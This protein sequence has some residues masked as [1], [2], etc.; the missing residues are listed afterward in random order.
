MTTRAPQWLTTRPIAHRGLHERARGII[1]NTPSAIG[2]AIDNHFAFEVDLQATLDGEAMVYHDDELGRLTDGHGA[3]REINSKDLRH[4][5]FRETTDRMIS[6]GE[7]CEIVSGRVTMVLELK[8]QFDDNDMLVRRVAS[9]LARYQGPVAAMSFDPFQ[10]H[11]LRR[12]APNV[13]RGLV[14]ENNYEQGEWLTLPP[15]KRN[16]MKHMRQ[17][18]HAQPQFIAYNINDLPSPAPWIARTL[19]GLP[20]LTWTVR[21]P[22]QRAHAARWTDQMIFETFIPSNE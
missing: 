1:E 12:L 3:L 22:D 5:P 6:L 16:M 11:A 2:A 7:L 14:A 8:S 20:L 10:V 4:V 19:F 13:V 15:A 17:A 9:V 18:F 21:T